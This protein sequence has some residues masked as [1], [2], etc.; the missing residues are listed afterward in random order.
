ME[1][2]HSPKENGES[3]ALLAG[4]ICQRPAGRKCV[5]ARS[6]VPIRL[7]ALQQDEAEG[8]IVFRP[9]LVRLAR[10]LCPI[11]HIEIGKEYVS[12]R[13]SVHLRQ[14]NAP[15]KRQRLAED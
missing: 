1:A 15:R 10:Q 5:R 6:S 14:I 3:G 7:S 2:E 13:R 12:R 11:G 8:I 9:G 4:Y